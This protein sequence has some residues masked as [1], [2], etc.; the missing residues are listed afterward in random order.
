MFYLAC[1]CYVCC[2][3]RRLQQKLYERENCH[4]L[5]E[6]ILPWIQ[7]PLWISMS[8]AIRNMTGAMHV[9]GVREYQLA[10]YFAITYVCYKS[11]L[12]FGRTRS[13]TP[14]MS[15]VDSK[16]TTALKFTDICY[17]LSAIGEEFSEKLHMLIC[18][19][20]NWNSITPLVAVNCNLLSF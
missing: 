9:Q 17:F 10:L 7:I 3:M 14:V 1:G 6:F 11:I 16:Q 5:K 8:L 4:P 20:V 18:Y 19:I 2:K 15:A 13:N 12:L